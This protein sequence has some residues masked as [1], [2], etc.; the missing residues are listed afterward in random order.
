MIK[1][2]IEVIENRIIFYEHNLINEPDIENRK[3]LLKLLFN[4]KPL[5]IKEKDEIEK[6]SRLKEQIHIFSSF[7][8]QELDIQKEELENNLSEIFQ[9]EQEDK[10]PSNY[11]D[12]RKRF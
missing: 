7:F 10:I 1:I 8:S 6:S 12:L 11:T 5:I 2:L 4:L 9:K 3:K